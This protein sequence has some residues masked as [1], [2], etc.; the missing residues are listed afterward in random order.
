MNDVDYDTY[1]DWTFENESVVVP[2]DS[3]GPDP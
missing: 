2:A 3:P 1:F